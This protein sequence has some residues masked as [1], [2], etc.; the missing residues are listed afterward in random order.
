[1]LIIPVA[2]EEILYRRVPRVE[3][4][5]LV[6][7]GRSI[8][9]SSAAFSDRS[10]RP[11]VDRAEL[12]H[13]DPTKTQRESSDGVVSVVTNDVRS[14]DTIVQNDGKGNLILTFRVDVEYV[15][16]LNHPTLLDNP[17]HAEIF[18]IPTSSNKAVFRRLCERL[19]QLANERPWEI[20]LQNLS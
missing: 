2:D 14:I 18:L 9:V 4:L 13:H 3:G 10:F 7:A 17:A 5:Y 6:Q 11:S 16:I 12:C 19:A 15:P 20:E 8:R 1:M